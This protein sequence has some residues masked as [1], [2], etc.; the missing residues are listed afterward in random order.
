LG[1]ADFIRSR[2]G[3]GAHRAHVRRAHVGRFTHQAAPL[4]TTTMRLNRRFRGKKTIVSEAGAGVRLQTPEG[5]HSRNPFAFC[6]ER[7]F[8]YKTPASVTLL[9]D[10]LPRNA[11]GKVGV[12][13][14]ARYRLAGQPRTSDPK[15]IATGASRHRIGPASF[16]ATYVKHAAG[17]AYCASGQHAEQPD[18]VLIIEGQHT[19]VEPTRPSSLSS[20]QTC[21]SVLAHRQRMNCLIGEFQRRQR[22]EP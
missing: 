2:R 17:L 5:F 14:P 12:L 8:D 9:T 13:R 21:G 19:V 16:T 4:G 10:P 6:A 20:S 7:L 22:L 3:S 1:S 15:R 11:N 18:L